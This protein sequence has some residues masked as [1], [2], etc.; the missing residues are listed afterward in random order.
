MSDR[1]TMAYQYGR[2]LMT[3]EIYLATLGR[4][5]DNVDELQALRECATDCVAQGA[6]DTVCDG[7]DRIVFGSKQADDPK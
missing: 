5:R 7:D 6:V 2:L 4:G 1:P 3:V